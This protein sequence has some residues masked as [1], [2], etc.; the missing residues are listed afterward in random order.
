MVL[1]SGWM[2][3]AEPPEAVRSTQRLASSSS[4]DATSHN[5]GKPL[6]GRTILITRTAE[7]NASEKAKLEELGAK[8][9][10]LPTIR[11]APP[12]S[13]GP[14]DRAISGIG[15]FD[16]IIFT[17]ANGVREFFKR[18]EVLGQ[19]ASLMERMKQRHLSIAC[20][21]LSTE[22]ELKAKGYNTD[23]VPKVFL[24]SSLGEE[25]AN[26]TNVRGRRILLARAEK[27][28][29]KIVEIL[30]AK[31]AIVTN[32]PV[33]STITGQGG[34]L[35]GEIFNSLTD[36]TL[37]SPSTVDGL[38]ALISAERI[39]SSKIMIHCIGPVTERAARASG[40]EVASVAR[41]HTIDG[42]VQSMADFV[43]RAEDKRK[44]ARGP[45]E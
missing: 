40:L 34:A 37:T 22:K 12:T 9:F 38:L 39:K 26:F 24:T 20:V 29:E 4:T 30:E 16:W 45:S 25:L 13:W 7:G 11:I 27:A 44:R 21:G 28:S 23:F 43:T 31:G 3:G 2:R 10:E 36:L 15:E 41:E 18:L 6:L 17:S 8:I 42:L 32:A 1:E 5:S 14:I 19:K 35:A 33:Y